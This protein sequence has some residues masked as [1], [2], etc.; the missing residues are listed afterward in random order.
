[1]FTIDY[2]GEFYNVYQG[3]VHI[4]TF[5]SITEAQDYVE[6]L[7]WERDNAFSELGCEFD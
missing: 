3:G 1:M 6:C 7:K 4:E 2:D 5:C